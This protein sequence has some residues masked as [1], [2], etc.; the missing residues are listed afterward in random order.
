MTVLNPNK[1]PFIKITLPF[2]A[3][4]IIGNVF[5]I[6]TLPLMALVSVSVLS[7]IVL[8]R[9]HN[10]RH[11]WLF[12]TSFYISLALLGMLA[13]K[14]NLKQTE[15]TP[16][17]AHSNYVIELNDKPILKSEKTILNSQVKYIQFADKLYTVDK[18]FI[19]TLPADTNILSLQAGDRLLVQTPLL[20]INQT[21]S[22]DG[23]DYKK[24]LARSGISGA[25]YI[26]KGRYKVLKGA[27]ETL[28]L[29]QWASVC[30]SKII[31]LYADAGVMG[32]QLS[33]LSALTVGYKKDLS[34]ELRET[35]SIAGAS[36][37]LALSGMHVAILGFLIMFLLKPLERLGKKGKYFS[38]VLTMLCLV[39]FAVLVGL[40]ASVVRATVMFALYTVSGLLRREPLSVNNLSVAAFVI[41][42]FS[43]QSLFDVGFQLSFCAILSIILFHKPIESLFV[44]K[45]KITRYVWSIVSISIS[46]QI[47]TSPVVMFY[48]NRFSVHF[49]L[50]NIVVIPLLTLILS[51]SLLLIATYPIASIHHAVADCLNFVI[52]QMNNFLKTVE[53]LPLSSI[54]DIYISPLVLASLILIALATSSYIS[55]RSPRRLLLVMLSLLTVCIAFLVQ[56]L[57]SVERGDR[58]VFYNSKDCATIHLIEHSGQSSIVFAKGIDKQDKIKRKYKKYWLRNGIR[59]VNNV[60]INSAENP[61]YMST[62]LVCFKDRMVAII[63]YD[64]RKVTPKESKVRVDFA[65]LCGGFR[66]RVNDI[67]NLFSARRIIVHSSVEKNI[68]EQI[69]SDCIKLKHSLIVLNEKG[70]LYFSV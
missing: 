48:F 9:N 32:D 44:A 38:F 12:A 10:L 23:F 43:P 45:H 21:F 64:T 49:L 27:S 70:D 59:K 29:R 35:Y 36:H 68:I 41:L 7:T 55:K 46:V 57:E 28:S 40:S 66:G 13:I 2:I 54:D 25:M 52:K 62:N 30:R 4:I 51:I 42:L 39:A 5:C 26:P 3:G 16:N 67:D 31:D 37:I 69:K 60:H 33:V 53:Q 22:L 14:A 1:S 18:Q 61:Y 63:D 56:T 19:F 47:L 65:Y 20:P 11:K 17:T 58:I 8:Y 6:D 34:E 50:T 15:F 24:Y